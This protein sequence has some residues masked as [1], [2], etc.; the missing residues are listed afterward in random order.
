MI[1][2]NIKKIKKNRY[3]KQETNNALIKNYRN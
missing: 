2:L 1:I 3:Q